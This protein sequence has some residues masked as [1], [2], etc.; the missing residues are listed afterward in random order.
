VTFQRN[1]DSPITINS[2][3][4]KINDAGNFTV[5][6]FR[7]TEQQF[8]GAQSSAIVIYRRCQGILRGIRIYNNNISKPGSSPGYP[9]GYIYI[10]RES[11]VTI[12]DICFTVV[13][14]TVRI[15]S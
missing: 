13:D 15:I 10:T 14:S 2:G 4:F 5:D 6:N 1:I 8:F 3:L 12:E 11:N 9:F 7:A